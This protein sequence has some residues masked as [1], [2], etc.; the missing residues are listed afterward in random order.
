MHP[1]A[2][3]FLIGAMLWIAWLLWD[4]WRTGEVWVKGGAK[5]RLTRSLDMHSF[6]HKVSREE[7]PLVYWLNM[8][9]FASVEV[10]GLY[11]LFV[12]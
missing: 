7:S 6:A 12:R 9:L 2:I 4:G 3:P 11:L 1:F 10:M 5:D 8:A